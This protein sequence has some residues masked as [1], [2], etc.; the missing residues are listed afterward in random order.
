MIAECAEAVRIPVIGN[1][2]IASGRHVEEKMRATKVRGLMIGRAAMS[3]P[4]IFREAREYLRT[5]RQP[6]PAPP[7]VRWQFI[8][9]HAR[10]ALAADT[11]RDERHV[12][13]RLRSRLMAYSKGLPGGKQLRV[14][15]T[16]VSSLAEL[17]DLAHGNMSQL[18][19]GHPTPAS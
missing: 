16:S 3:Y 4:W 18:E 12:F 6:D 11:R 7:S 1:G 19:C 15:F 10:L 2:D 9:R 17:E 5:G 14:R 8:L 13:M